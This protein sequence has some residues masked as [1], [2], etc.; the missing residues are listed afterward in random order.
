MTNEF[1]LQTFKVA[2]IAVI[3][4]SNAETALDRIDRGQTEDR[5]RIDKRQTKN[6]QRTHR[7]DRG[8]R[9][10]R[11]WTD[12]GQTGDRQKTDRGQTGDRQ[13]RFE[14]DKTDI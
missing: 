11:Q 6:R 10:D 5:R 12:R 3:P 13:D 9:E 7:R 4:L 1:V 14:T 8:Q 2:F